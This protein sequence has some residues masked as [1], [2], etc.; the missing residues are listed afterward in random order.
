MGDLLST[1]NLVKLS[2]IGNAIDAQ[3]PC[4]PALYSILNFEA[5]TQELSG[6]FS[7][8]F[9]CEARLQK[10]NTDRKIDAMLQQLDAL[11]ERNAE[12]RQ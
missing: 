4:D 5:L 6:L 11:I 8:V 3:G 1:V 12:T 7:F 2:S 9:A 10:N